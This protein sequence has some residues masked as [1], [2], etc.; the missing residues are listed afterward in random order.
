MQLY[1]LHDSSTFLKTKNGAFPVDDADARRL[2][3][4]GYGVFHSAN[5][6]SGRRI[7]A[8]LCSIDWWFC[9][10]DD[11]SKDVQYNKLI[12]CPL[13]PSWV[14]ESKRGYHAYWRP[15]EADIRSWKR[16]VRWGI[17]PSLGGDPRATDVTRILRA[18]GFLHQKS[19]DDPFLVRTLW[20][21][22]AMYT[23]QQMLD[24]FPSTEPDPTVRRDERNGKGFWSGVSALDGRDAIRRLSGHWSVTREM[25]DLE[26]MNN[27]NANIIVLDR[28]GIRRDSGSFVDA[29]GRLGNVAD[30]PTIAAWIN[31]YWNDGYRTAAKAIK[32]LWPELGEANG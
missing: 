23:E 14:I 5:T 15:V 10:I 7:G 27:G 32:E 8:N 17:V 3:S 6:F 24:A 31:W 21:I 1:A 25:F 22:P 4:D 13:R 29:S 16:I 18:P 26:E 20:R 19:P 30:G 28:R 12:N 11:G 2:N 9:E